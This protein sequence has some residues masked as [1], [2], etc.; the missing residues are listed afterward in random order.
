M[1]PNQSYP[2]ESGIEF[3]I[4]CI[5]AEDY[6]KALSRGAVDVADII[7][8]LNQKSEQNSVQK[9]ESI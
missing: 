9:E 5:K 6:L 2:H 1:V 4:H 7:E 8:S 3:R